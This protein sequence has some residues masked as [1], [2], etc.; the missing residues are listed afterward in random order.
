MVKDR[1]LIF[2]AMKKIPIAFFFCCLSL[3]LLIKGT[4]AQKAIDFFQLQGNSEKLFLRVI[5]EADAISAGNGVVKIQLPD[6]STGAAD[7]VATSDPDA[8][9]VRI[10][11]PYGTRSWRREKTFYGK[12]YGGSTDEIA[13]SI[14]PSSD[15]GFALC[16]RTDSYGA[17]SDDF[18]L[19]KVDEDGTFDWGK[20]M[21]AAQHGFGYSIIQ[22]NTGGYLVSGYEYETSSGTND[23]YIYH[24][25]VNGNDLL[26]GYYGT[27]TYH[28]RAYC[29]IQASDNNFVLTGSSSTASSGDDV[30]VLKINISSGATIWSHTIGTTTHDCGRS[31]IQRNDGSFVVVGQTQTGG[32]VYDIYL[33]L[34]NSGGTSDLSV[35][36]GGSGNEV[37]YDVINTSDGNILIAGSTNSIGAGIED[38]YLLKR[39]SNGDAIWST[40]LGGSNYD[41]ARAV[42]EASDG[43]LLIAGSTHS[44]GAG[45]ADL[46]LIKTDNSGN[47]IWS[48]VFGGS[49]RDVGMD[50]YQDPNGCIYVCGETFSYGAGNNDALL[51][52]FS[53]DGKTCLGMEVTPDSDNVNM[54]DFTATRIDHFNVDRTPLPSRIIKSHCNPVKSHNL[55]NQGPSDGIINITP[56]VTT[57]CN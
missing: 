45:N 43:G 31:I 8:S 10:R 46:W 24:L 42:C 3:L 37:G 1:P 18:L 41:W 28:E 25:D 34:L 52:K 15:G 30:Y 36:I 39:A 38:I 50:V 27:T 12:C 14:A 35:T 55:N 48:W 19:L 16:G 9:E 4:N 20:A 54:G 53:P 6:G 57:I 11:T 26:S 2:L 47:P 49:D 17:G 32:P 40:T 13:S 56:S 51:V 5:S 22:T 33:L 23:A 44:Y 29:G 21:G 7:L